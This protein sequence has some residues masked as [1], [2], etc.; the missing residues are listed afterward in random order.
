MTVQ[1]AW[2]GRAGESRLC[3]GGERGPLTS[4]RKESSQNQTCAGIGLF[5]PSNSRASWYICLSHAMNL[6]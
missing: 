4:C 3:L 6:D 5:V 2:R 1:S